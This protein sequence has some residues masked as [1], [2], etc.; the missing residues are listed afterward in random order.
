M[1]EMVGMVNALNDHNALTHFSLRL[2]W[3][4]LD[5]RNGPWLLFR[6]GAM[7]LGVP[8]KY[9]RILL[10]AAGLHDQDVDE[11]T[12]PDDPGQFELVVI[13]FFRHAPGGH[14]VVL[15]IVDDRTGET[16]HGVVQV[17]PDIMCL[18]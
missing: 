10:F 18:S 8:P 5:T 11:G 14:D 13:K 4:R 3:V 17:Q 12:V 16:D 2:F 6:K 7:A 9:R 1:V 15:V